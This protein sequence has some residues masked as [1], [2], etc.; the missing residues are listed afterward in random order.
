MLLQ[1]MAICVEIL[2]TAI[3]YVADA[4]QIIKT[5]EFV[6]HIEHLCW[7]FVHDKDL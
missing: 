3:V 4:L 2:I 6:K 5:P 7:I 1:S